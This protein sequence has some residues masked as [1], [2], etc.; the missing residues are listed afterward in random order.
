MIDVDIVALHAS[1][2]HAYEG[3]PADGPRP[4]PAPVAQD[5]VEVRAGKG[6]VGDRYYNHPAHQKAAVTFFAA[7]SLDALGITASPLL[8]RRN[9]IL[10]G[11]PIDDLAARR[12]TPGSVFSIDGVRFQAY[13]PANPCAWMDV[14]FGEGAFRGLRGHGGVRC[15]PLDDGVLQV[16]PAQ[17]EIWTPTLL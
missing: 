13:R 5:K 14:V 15:V 9:V 7:E 10:R 16:G 3:R 17:L 11:F 8:T 12:G 1:R 6:I 4:D 2:V